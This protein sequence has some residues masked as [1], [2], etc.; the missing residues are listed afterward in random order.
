MQ[1]AGA[2]TILTGGSRG[3][4]RA[5]AEAAAVRGARVGLIAR[6]EDDLRSA[7]AAI[8]DARYAVADV[9]DPGALAAAINRLEQ[10]LGPTEVLVANAGIGAYGAFADLSEE[11]AERVV[12]VNVLGTVHALRAVVPGMIARRRGH[13]VTI[14]SIAGRIGA[15]FE[16]IYS[17][18]KFAGVGLT[19]ALAVELAPYGIGVS[20][21]NPGPVATGFADARGHPYDRARPRPVPAE[22]VARAVVR[23]VEG[24]R[25]E[26]YVPR[27]FRPAVALRHLVPP[28]FRWGT[29][30]SFSRE[31]AEDRRRR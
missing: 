10:A 20:V 15:P 23:A 8:V 21:V 18:S 11:E 24:D 5:V 19:E 9:A 31:L 16:A 12:R 1:W 2:A 6:D 30:R 22:D 27:S 4:G 7:A 25:T 17:A 28:L 26:Q 29:R 13:L 3:I 14:G